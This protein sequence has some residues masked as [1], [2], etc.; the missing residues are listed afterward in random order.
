MEARVRFFE[1]RLG[2]CVAADA[3]LH[4]DTIALTPSKLTMADVRMLGIAKARAA[5]ESLRRT[6]TGLSEGILGHGTV[7]A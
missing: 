1:M 7:M 3:A 4:P 2:P 5:P 6:F